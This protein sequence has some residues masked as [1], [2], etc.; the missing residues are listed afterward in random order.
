MIYV[1]TFFAHIG[2]IRFKKFCDRQNL[3]A[4]MMPVPRTL[5]S[6]CGTCVEFEA[7]EDY[8]LHYE[9]EELEEVVKQING[10]YIS[11]YRAD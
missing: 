6:S 3:K 11:I 10:E 5:S 1:A 9:S 4:H 8:D 2:T 7:P